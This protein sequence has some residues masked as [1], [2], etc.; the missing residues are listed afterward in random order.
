LIVLFALNREHWLNEKG[1]LDLVGRFRIV[2]GR[3]CERVEAIWRSV[4]KDADSLTAAMAVVREL[5]DEVKALIEGD[6]L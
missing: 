5:N 6:G 2:P 1:A 3:F 4:L